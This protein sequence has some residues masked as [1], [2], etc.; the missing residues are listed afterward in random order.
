MRRPPQPDKRR[1]ARRRGRGR[2]GRGRTRAPAAPAARYCAETS[3]TNRRCRA[4]AAPVRPPRPPRSACGSPRRPRSAL[5]GWKHHCKRRPA[6]ST[7]YALRRLAS[8]TR[9]DP[10]DAD[11]VAYCG[12]HPRAAGGGS[13]PRLSAKWNALI[14]VGIGFYLVTLDTSIVNIALP[15]LESAF[16]IGPED[17]LWVPL[18][19]A[20]VVTGL[21]LTLGRLGDM[22]GR[23]AFFI[24]G[25]TLFGVAVGVNAAA[26]SFPVIIGARVVQGIGAA[27]VLANGN[28][29][30]TDIFPASERGKALGTAGA[31]VGSGL[32]SG[33]VLGGFLIDRFGWRAIFWPQMPVALLGA[34]L[35]LWLLHESRAAAGSRR[36]D[37][38]EDWGW[39]SA[40]TI[41]AFVVAML[42]LGL[43]ILVERRVTNP[44]INLALFRNRL[45]A[46]ATL[47]LIFFYNASAS[48]TLLM[49][50]YLTGVLH[51]GD[52]QAG[53]ALA[54]VPV[55][56]LV[57]SPF[58][59]ALSDRFGSRLLATGGMGCVVLALAALETLT[60]H[61]SMAGVM[62]RLAI[63]GLGTALFQSPNSSTIMGSV[64]RE[65]LGTASAMN[66]TG[67]NI[68]QA[69]G[70]AIAGT[71]FAARAAARA[72]VPGNSSLDVTTLPPAA[73]LTGIE[74]ALFVALIVAAFGMAAAFIRG[75]EHD[76]ATPEL[77]KQILIVE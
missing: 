76:D 65:Y 29:I 53:V 73:L 9:A 75:K 68:G 49:P 34:L 13:M 67:R 74:A 72:G 44:I 50:F 33:P 59:G 35:G 57:L 10:A 36:V 58:T 52:F 61:T 30:I 54:A 51:Y 21:T 3:A 1:P 24:A 38:G 60:R 31:A 46:A 2:A 71:V 45:F 43:L 7:S 11:G 66:A 42:A 23:K 63:V 6:W 15:T 28:A 48:V 39:Q 8:S 25:L 62:L 40:R 18:G 69:M 56:V 19:Y 26:P 12:T 70:F 20:L 22:L 41:A 55:V 32:A 64:P 16:H 4:P 37:R 77:R 14:V 17:V 27:V 5:P 47:S